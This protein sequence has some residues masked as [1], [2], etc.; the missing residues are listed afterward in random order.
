MELGG[1]N[2]KCFRKNTPKLEKGN[3]CLIP[4]KHTLVERDHAVVKGTTTQDHINS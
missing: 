3:H 4:I 2:F 1:G